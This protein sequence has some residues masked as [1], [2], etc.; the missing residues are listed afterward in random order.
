MFG[1]SLS[2]R[3]IWAS[4]SK[5]ISATRLRTTGE[6]VAVKAVTRGMFSFL[7]ILPSV[8]YAGRKLS[9]HSETQCASSIAACVI[10]HW[11]NWVTSSSFWRTSGFARMIFAPA[12]I[13]SKFAWRSSFVCPPQ[14]T[15]F[16]MP[17]SSMRLFWSDIRARSGYMTRVAP[18]RSREGIKKH[19]DLPAPVGKS[20]IWRPSVLLSLSF[21]PW[22][23]RSFAASRMFAITSCCHGYR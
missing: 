23:S 2:L 3:T 16:E 10:L 7:R 20:T 8:R 1:R 14:K 19:S 22:S 4:P 9:P 21:K 5:R 15:T 17:P 12:F 13:F 11:L 18:G 6:A